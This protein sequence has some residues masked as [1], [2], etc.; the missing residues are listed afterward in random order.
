[1]VVGRGSKKERVS[2]SSICKG[3]KVKM[4]LLGK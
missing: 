2:V 4:I 3:K 1:M